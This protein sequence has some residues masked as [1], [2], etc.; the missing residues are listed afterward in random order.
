[1]GLASDFSAILA[2]TK[3]SHSLFYVLHTAHDL[4]VFA[5]RAFHKSNH[6]S[7]E[8]DNQGSRL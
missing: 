4:C 1:M 8:S 6:S 3:A 2:Q 7:S 5:V